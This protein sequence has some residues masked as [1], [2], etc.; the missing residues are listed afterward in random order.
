M[1]A[2]HRKLFNSILIASCNVLWATRLPNGISSNGIAGQKIE[3]QVI[4]ISMKLL[5]IHKIFHVHGWSPHTI[6]ESFLMWI[7]VQHTSINADEQKLS[8]NLGHHYYRAYCPIMS[9]KNFFPLKKTRKIGSNSE[10]KKKLSDREAENYLWFSRPKANDTH[11]QNRKKGIM[12]GQK[13]INRKS[14]SII[15]SSKLFTVLNLSPLTSRILNTHP[16][17]RTGLKTSSYAGWNKKI[18]TLHHDIV[19]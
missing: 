10:N 7:S 1:P 13:K 2:D 11:T 14:F 12:K 4:K 6:F 16:H 5:M 8:I 17:D 18:I 19:T 15:M 3:F 9:R